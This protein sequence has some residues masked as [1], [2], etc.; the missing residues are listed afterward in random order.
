MFN[1]L[2]IGAKILIVM[3]ITSMGALMAIAVI[4]FSQ[5]LDLTHYAGNANA[6]LGSTS[7]QES[8]TALLD[9]AED[10]LNKVV[11]EKA[12]FYNSTLHMVS[13][14]LLSARDATELLY[15]NP[16][17]FQGY[18][19]PRPDKTAAGVPCAKGFLAG[20]GEMDEPTAEEFLLLSNLEYTLA[21][22]FRNNEIISNFYL[23]T[24][25]GISYRYSAKNNYD[26]T[27]DPRQR[28]WYK[29]TFSSD[30]TKP[31]WQDT[32]LDSYGFL[33][34]TCAA[35][36]TNGDHKTHGVIATDITMSTMTDSILNTRIGE[37]GYAFLMDNTG[38]YIA[39]PDYMKEGFIADAKQNATPSMLE[40]ISCMTKGETSVKTVIL[41]DNDYY[42]A[43]A[44]L[45]ETGWSLGVLVPLQEVISPALLTKETIDTYS[46]ET[47]GII[48]DTLLRVLIRFLVLFG[49]CT[50]LF[51]MFAF[52]L[53][54]AIT[55]PIELLSRSVD[56]IG[57]G[58]W[59]TKIEIKGK[60]E[61]AELAGT[62]NN[63]TDELKHYVADLTR[64]TAE[65]ERIG[66]ELNVATQIQRDMLPSTFPAFPE[67]RQ[68]DLYAS[69]DPAKEVG[70]DFYDF[71][72]LDDDHLALV[73]GD[74]SGKGV[75]AALF[76]VISKTLIKNRA[77]LGGTPA[78][79]LADVNNQL[80]EGNDACLFCTAWLGILDVHT[81]EIRAASAG[82]E[83]PVIQS[84]DGSYSMM[85]DK[86]GLAL[87]AMDGLR[88]KDY[89]FT[90]EKRGTLFVYTDGVP[91]AT[92]GENV[93]FGNDRMV[94]ALNRLRT[95]TPEETLKG[96]AGY[97]DDFVGDAPQFDDLTMLCLR[98]FGE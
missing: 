37:G 33:C 23:G 20:G 72:L 11:T 22:L 43:F 4:S 31:L 79:I 49:A 60:D 95:A 51:V 57:K 24:E 35:P 77:L 25:S 53:S 66:A 12:A 29:E 78:E 46:A 83:Y 1:N 50:M 41:D 17:N 94:E 45:K 36:F 8:E 97:V 2:K 14:S 61:I 63:M 82:H 70:G 10:Y 26:P 47:N 42:L 44:P 89:S 81:G 67:Y 40:A 52:I 73:I 69:M 96:M 68:F 85:R 18:V 93:L 16:D 64:V 15:C 62:F 80:C 59:D 56:K 84:A 32:Y 86:H 6:V 30:H 87:A 75:P 92:N 28:G 91:E 54:S 34:V 90:L 3:L 19:I 7:A 76:M 71:F 38:S 27:Y 39:H 5:M 55:R 48:Q 58:D 88:Y 21:P 65:K 98:Y 9:Q 74:V 13:S